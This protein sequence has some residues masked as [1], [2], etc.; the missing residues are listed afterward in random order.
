MNY[1]TF[2]NLYFNRL[3]INVKPGEKNLLTSCHYLFILIF[4]KNKASIIFHGVAV[5]FKK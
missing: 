4:F 1:T 5:G 2:L 3:E